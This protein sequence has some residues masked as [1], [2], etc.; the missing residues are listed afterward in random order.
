MTV[1]QCSNWCL[2]TL[3][4]VLQEYCPAGRLWDIVSPLVKQQELGL[5]GGEGCTEEVTIDTLGGGV[6]RSDVI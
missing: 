2:V 1:S 4:P 3:P 6:D 5:A